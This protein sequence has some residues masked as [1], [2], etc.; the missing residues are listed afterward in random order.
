MGGASQIARVVRKVGLHD[1]DDVLSY[2]LS[3]SAEERV[4]MVQQ[5]RAEYYGGDAG[6]AGVLQTVGIGVE[7]DEIAEAGR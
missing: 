1:R 5:L 3:R 2:W 4:A 7:P 6:L